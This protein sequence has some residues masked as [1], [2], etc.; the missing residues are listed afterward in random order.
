MGNL[1]DVQARNIKPGDKQI[2]DGSVGNLWLFPSSKKGRAKWMFIF[3]SPETKKRRQMGL[4][5]YPDVKIEEARR[6]ALDARDLLA[7]KIDPIEKRKRDELLELNAKKRITFETAA[8]EKYKEKLPTW[9]NKKHAN[10]WIKTL[11]DYTFG[12]IGSRFVDELRIADFANCLRDVWHEHPET[13]SRVKQRCQEIMTW[14]VAHEFT[15]SNPVIAIEQILGKQPSKSERI[16]H[17]PAMAWREIPDFIINTLSHGNQV[18][19]I[20]LEFLILTAARSGEVRGAKW[21]EIDTKNKIWT[22]PKERMKKKK[23]HKV[24]LSERS[25]E[26]LELQ[27]K[28]YPDSE[29]VFPSFRGKVLTDMVFTMFL[30]K[31]KVMSSEP[32]V[33]AT[34]HGFRSS[35]RDWASESGYSRD[36]AEKAL[37]HE[38]KNSTEKAYHRTDLLEERR[39]MMESW[40]SFVVSKV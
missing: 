9:K 2:A 30:R 14:C 15:E 7:K 11:E 10:Q 35:F 39:S 37:A 36:L 20:G 6:R 1:T 24:P 28:L 3:T 21:V 18:T 31:H 4:G 23:S 27:K 40:S 29:L 38:I 5:V 16:R 19:R 32:G 34:A 26:L 12:S 17:H 13:G 22:I 33:I 8:R 25:L